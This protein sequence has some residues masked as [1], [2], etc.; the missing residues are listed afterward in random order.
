[1]RIKNKLMKKEFI[2]ITFLI[3][4]LTLVID[5]KELNAQPPLLVYLST[6][7]PT[8]FP[9][10]DVIIKVE[11]REMD[12][13][14]KVS[15]ADVWIGLVPPPGPAIAFPGTEMGIGDYFYTYSSH[16]FCTFE[17]ACTNFC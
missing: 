6:N 9:G 3:L 8:Y 4:S 1:M 7:K 14:T 11:V 10:E 2:I 16:Y 17:T 15:G 12:G 13:V 5:F